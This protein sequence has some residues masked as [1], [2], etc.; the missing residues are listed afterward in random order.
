MAGPSVHALGYQFVLT[1][2]LVNVLIIFTVAMLYNALFPWR[3]Y[4]SILIQRSA[5]GSQD[6]WTTETL[7]QKQL[8]NALQQINHFVDISN[9]DLK[10]IFQLVHNN[11]N[12]SLDVAQLKLGHYYSN[13]ESGAN[14]SVRQ[15]I[16]ASEGE[17]S[18]DSF[19]IYKTVAGKGRSE[20]GA[21][22]RQEFA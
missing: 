8:D 15:L 5:A 20:T 19:I 3:R 7:G 14:W 4:P 22:R 12:T 2:V 16:D 6:V 13:G 9:E 18:K 21:M 17:P 11:P 1:P 10:K